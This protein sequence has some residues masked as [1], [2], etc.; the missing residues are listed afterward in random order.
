[1]LRPLRYNNRQQGQKTDQ[2]HGFK[3]TGAH[4]NTC[5][6]HYTRRQQCVNYKLYSVFVKK[7]L[8][9]KELFFCLSYT[10]IESMYFPYSQFSFIQIIQTK[11]S[12][13]KDLRHKMNAYNR[14]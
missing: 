7:S 10:F 12:T 5:Q 14:A 8:K 1:M 9:I 11:K 4:K 13:E 2:H 6:L 3:L